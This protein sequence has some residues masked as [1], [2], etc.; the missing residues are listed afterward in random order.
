MPAEPRDELAELRQA[1]TD[2]ADEN[3]DLRDYAADLERRLAGATCAL[4]SMRGI[5]DVGLSYGSPC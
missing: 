3:A 1:V 2:L 5:A 4:V